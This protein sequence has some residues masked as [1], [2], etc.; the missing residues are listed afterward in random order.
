VVVPYS[1]GLNGPYAL[2]DK[3]H[4]VDGSILMDVSF[5]HKLHVVQQGA[6]CATCH[7]SHGVP[8]GTTV[9]NKSLVN[10]DLRIV[11][12]TQAT[13]QPV[14]NPQFDS[15]NRTCSLT[16]HGFDHQGTSY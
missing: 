1:S 6:S 13:T 7:S 10:F 11:G 9:N 15:V 5:P 16:C 8:G 12:P 4:D 14:P 3:C 2:C